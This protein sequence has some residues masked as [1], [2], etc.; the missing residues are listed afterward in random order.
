MSSDLAPAILHS[1]FC[2]LP[3]AFVLP[4]P[5]PASAA[6]HT[7]RTTSPEFY[8]RSCASLYGRLG[9]RLAAIV[10]R[11]VEFRLAGRFAAQMK[12][13]LDFG[14][15]PRLAPMFGRRIEAGLAAG[16]AT[17]LAAL[18]DYRLTP[19]F[20]PPTTC[21][22][23]QTVTKPQVIVLRFDAACSASTTFVASQARE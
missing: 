5:C 13:V 11:P 16:S 12:P 7:S 6:A 22:V 8:T 15:K 2:L 17:Q 23:K 10:A 1:P 18:L 9:P 14:Q 20:T 4:R 21:S 3:S 19:G